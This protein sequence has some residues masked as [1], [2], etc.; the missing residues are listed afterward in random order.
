MEIGILG[1][2]QSGKS[3]LFQI[4]TSVKSSDVYGE[5]TVRGIAKIPDVRFTKLVEIFEPEKVT[6]ASIPFV[7]VN[8]AGEGGWDSIRQSIGS[9]DSILHVVDCHTTGDPAEMIK[10]YKKL[11]EELIISDL[12]IVEKR[13]E[14]LLK[15]PKNTLGPEE[16]VQTKIMPALK[17]HLEAGKPLRDMKLSS[18]ETDAIRNFAFWSIRPELIVLN[19]AE[20]ASD[21]SNQFGFCTTSPVIA[22][23]CQ[24][25]AEIASLSESDRKEFLDSLGIKAPAFQVII[26][27]AFSQLGRIYY[28][29]VG[30]DEVRAW[31]I[32]KG[33]TAPRAAAAIHK[34][35]ERGFIK[36]EVVGFNDFINSGKSLAG[37]KSAGK[38]RLEGKDYIVEDGD[39]IS[40]RFNV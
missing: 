18:Q 40:F 24:I 21:P 34:D 14:R 2:G 29:T 8:A 37:A 15:L 19:I 39:I 17:D 16:S 33:S 22:I 4:M 36:A 25:E 10:R 6:P 11:E 26:Q 31:I 13:I 5:P 35:F 23:C 9:V 38:L 3:T 30:E 32:K 1:L 12:M 20:G 28:F 27:T 7:D